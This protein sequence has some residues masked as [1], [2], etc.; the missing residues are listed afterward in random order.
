MKN[1][2]ILGGS[3]IIAGA[4]VG[5]GL[6]LSK[7]Q[8]PLKNIPDTSPQEEI[9]IKPVSAEDHIQGP[10]DAKITII[11]Y[12]DPE[13]PYC[14]VF[15]ETMNEIMADKELSGKIAW[16]YRHFPI[17]SL[18]TKAKY[19]SQAME[20]AAEIGGNDG[21]WQ[22]TN[23]LYQTTKSNDSFDIAT[24]PDLAS[25]V[26]LD[27]TKFTEC[28]KSGK[29]VETV[30]QQYKDAVAAGGQGTPYSIILGPNERKIPI[31]G[32]VRAEALKI[33]LNSLLSL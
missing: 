3:I 28:L 9:I 6:Y 15:H 31:Q 14:K 7:K 23:K 12:S 21:F 24:L 22:F 5:G 2:L 29:M 13:C 27:K 4:F 33:Q 26:G 16:V 20:C 18:H 1:T 8:V 32:A 25:S 10:R 17:E 19:E 30:E 11:E